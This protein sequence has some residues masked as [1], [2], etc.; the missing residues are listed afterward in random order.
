MNFCKVIFFWLQKFT[1]F[2][3]KEKSQT[4]WLRELYGNF[5]IKKKK[6]HFEEKKVLKLSSFFKRFGK[7]FFWLSSFEI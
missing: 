5:G 1:H 3:I 6:S 4:M 7:F 2:S